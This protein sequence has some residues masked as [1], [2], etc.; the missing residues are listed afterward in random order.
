MLSLTWKILFGAICFRQEKAVERE[1]VARLPASRFQMPPAP[2]AVVSGYHW[3]S[4]LNLLEAKNLD[5]NSTLTWQVLPFPFR[6]WVKTH[7]KSAFVRLYIYDNSIFPH[8]SSQFIMSYISSHHL[9]RQ[10]NIIWLWPCKSVA[11]ESYNH[12]MFRLGKIL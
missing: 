8:L 1:V 4:T 7:T 10:S 5:G 2:S 9:L 6:Q 3:L 11:M 12:R